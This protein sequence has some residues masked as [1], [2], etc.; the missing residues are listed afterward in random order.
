MKLDADLDYSI[1]I[2]DIN[3]FSRTLVIK[4]D[5]SADILNNTMSLAGYSYDPEDKKTWKYY[6]NMAGD[7]H[8]SNT[9]MTV[10]SL[11]NDETINF[12]KEMLDIHLGTRRGYQYGSPM[13]E[14]LAARYP[15]QI[16]LIKGI[17]NSVDYEV[18]T[19][20][21]DY[22]IVWYDTTLI[23][24]GEDNVISQ[25]QDWIYVWTKGAYHAN[26]TLVTEDLMHQYMMSV[27][28]MFIPSRMLLIRN[29][30]IGTNYAHDFHIWSHLLS[31]ADMVK[32]KSFFNRRQVLWL[33][34]NLIW[35]TRNPGTEYTF[36]K[37][38]DNIL[39]ERN[40]PIAAYDV[41][42]NSTGLLESESLQPEVEFKR[43]QLNMED[44]VSNAVYTRTTE[45][46]MEEEIIL[47]R[48]NIAAYDNDRVDIE[49]DLGTGLSSV[50]PSKVLESEMRDLSDSIA[51]PLSFTLLNEW[52]R[53]SSTQQYTAVISVTNPVNGDVMSMTVQEAF[54]LYL[55]AVW[56][57]RDITLETI[58]YYQAVT[59][60]RLPRP[61]STDVKNKLGSKWVTDTWINYAT[62]LIPTVGN[63]V[64]T[65]TFY[66]TAVE[67]NNATQLLRDMYVYRTWADERAEL[68]RL[69]YEYFVDHLCTTAVG[70]SY[71][72][73]F[74]NNAFELD[75]LAKDDWSNLATTLLTVSTGL[76]TANVIKLADVQKAMVD[77][78][79]QMS[80]YNIQVLCHIN[81]EAIPQLD[82]PA[83]RPRQVDMGLSLTSIAKN[84]IR[85]L[86]AAIARSQ[87]P[88]ITMNGIDTSGGITKSWRYDL[89][90]GVGGEARGRIVKRTNMDAMVVT[91]VDRNDYPEEEPRENT[92][93]YF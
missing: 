83:L 67:I 31:H 55:Y 82:Y 13:Y 9:M 66:N 54:W 5:I 49:T 30:N 63:I 91:A 8:P 73:F 26:Y 32:Y 17:L 43:V 87:K 72:D 70:T 42:Y 34:R 81:E 27:L 16:P 25:L 38:I 10:R 71:Q 80:S 6:M 1:Y 35:V 59:C 7:Y 74:V 47:A 79:V 15:D 2:D 33:Y 51:H 88:R 93:V 22:Q 75:A 28:Y 65:E 57:V 85:I 60:L 58:P 21:V 36:G 78:T 24:E 23:G 89:S 76:D 53:L 62:G 11:D 61:M 39:T 45:Q 92:V 18:S 4:S 20:A 68:E 90:N 52:V 86:D 40:V 50:T 41:V 84:N 64:A 56:K 69:M 44:S 3:K 37:L 19:N 12:T 14:E 77:F 29:N 46:I 48:D